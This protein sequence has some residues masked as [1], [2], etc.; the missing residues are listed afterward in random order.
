M[1]RA[2]GLV[3]HVHEEARQ[4]IALELWH[5]VAEAATARIRGAFREKE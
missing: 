3:G 1:A 5:R 2:V 4:P